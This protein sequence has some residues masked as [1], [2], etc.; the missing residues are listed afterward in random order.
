MLKFKEIEYVIKKQRSIQDYYNDYDER[1]KI[2]I[3]INC[4]VHNRTIIIE[5]AIIQDICN[6]LNGYSGKKIGPKTQEK[7]INE[8]N[9]LPF[10]KDNNLRVYL[11]D[12]I[13]ICYTTGVNSMYSNVYMKALTKN[14]FLDLKYNKIYNIEDLEIND[15]FKYIDDIE[16]YIKQINLAKENVYNK[17]NELQKIVNDYNILNNNQ[18]VSKYIELSIRKIEY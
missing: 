14:I 1:Q 10:I 2:Q 16:D 5:N 18:Y 11:D 17:F 3:R 4:L 12:S 15:R 6:I 9:N 7:I 13:M 8:V